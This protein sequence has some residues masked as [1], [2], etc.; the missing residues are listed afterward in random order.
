MRHEESR[1]QK[2]CVKWF[3]YEFPNFR[4]LLFAVPN[5][6]SR[7]RI[8]GA[9]MKEEG[10]TAGVADLLFLYPSNGYHGL[11]I[12]MKNGDKGRQQTTQKEWQKKVEEAGY[13]Y[14]I[15]RS[16]AQFMSEIYAY[17]R[18]NE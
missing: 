9:I 4:L 8:E 5:G 17:L 16:F 6:G 15:C 1:L 13:K 12:E 18:K 7:R 3:R 11:C 2:A 14:I 10:V